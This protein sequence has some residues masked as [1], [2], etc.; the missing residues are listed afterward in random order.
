MDFDAEQ[1]LTPELHSGERL[2]W[3]GRPR[4][5][6]RLTAADAVQI[7][8]SLFWCGF[9]A[10]WEYMAYRGHAPLPMLAM[11][12]V[13]ALLGVYLLVGRFF[14]DAHRR[15]RLYYGLTEE[16]V[17]LLT[18]GA[19]RQ[20]RSLP[21]ASVQEVTLKERGDGTGDIVFGLASAPAVWLSPS[22]PRAAR[23]LL[24][25]LEG[26]E[27]VRELQDQLLRAQEEQR[28]AQLPR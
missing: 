10:F 22:W 1:E 27:N 21:L 8:F 7:P 6:F 11:G 20:V 25:T 14:V 15:S 5:G 9:V 23:Y 19:R 24:P 12:G 4:G 18:A 16:R 17:L 2:L 28:R 13:F 26:V 3:S